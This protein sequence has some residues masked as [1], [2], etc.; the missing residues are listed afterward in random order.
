MNNVPVSPCASCP[1]RDC[2][3][4]CKTWEEWFRGIWRDIRKNAHRKDN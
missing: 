1:Q 3:K 4:I 2:N